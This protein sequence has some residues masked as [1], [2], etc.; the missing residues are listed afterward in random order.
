MC[1]I[2]T[3]DIAID[4]SYRYGEFVFAKRFFDFFFGQSSKLCPPFLKKIPVL[5]YQIDLKIL[6]HTHR[7]KVN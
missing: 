5:L 3:K 7:E 6:T 1:E 4:L 2:S